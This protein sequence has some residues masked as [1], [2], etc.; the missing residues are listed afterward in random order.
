ETHFVTS[1]TTNSGWNG[2]IANSTFTQRNGSLLVPSGAI[3]MRCS[4]VSGGSGTLTGVMIIDD[5]SVARVAPVVS[6]NFWANSTFETGSNLDQTNGTP[7]NWNRG[8]SDGSIDQVTTNN[9]ASPRHALAVVDFNAATY[10]EWY[11]DVLL[12][13]NASPGDLLDVKWSEI[14]GITNGEM[15]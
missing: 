11:S 1:Q 3:K 14:Y 2:T 4:L 10:G 15:R 6:G 7:A 5:L 8:G 12:S 13:G 9:S